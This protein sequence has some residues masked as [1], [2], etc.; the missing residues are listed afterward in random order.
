MIFRA[1]RS[2][3]LVVDVQERLLPVMAEPDGVVAR[4]RLLIEAARRLDV[5]IVASEQ[6]PKGLG[7]TVAALRT[8]LPNGAVQEKIEFSCAANPAIRARIEALGRP[9]IVICGI[10]AHVCVAQSALGFVAAGYRVAVATDAISSRRQADREV[11]LARF[12]AEGVTLASSEMI[13]FE[14]LERADTDAFKTMIKL[15]K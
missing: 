12:G 3:L 11:A 10:E 2:I 1:E 6:Y 8:L 13:V 14:W 7:A 9:E 15:I 5:P 4:G